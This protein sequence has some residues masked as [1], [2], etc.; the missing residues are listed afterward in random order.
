MQ[1]QQAFG[2]ERSMQQPPATRWFT[3]VVGLALLAAVIA[4]S[5]H[6]SES[7]TFARLAERARPGWILLAIGLQLGTHLAQGQVFRIVARAGGFA[8]GFATACRLGLAKLFVDQAVPSAG[9]SGTVVLA[10]GLERR[11]MRRPVVAAGVAV[12][13]ASYYAAYVACLAVALALATARG[14]LNALILVASL[15]LVVFAAA[16]S[17]VVIAMS[18]RSVY[19]L[20][21]ALLRLKVVRSVFGFIG[22]ADPAL[23]RSTRLLLSTTFYQVV[24]VLCDAASVWVLLRSLGSHGSPSG[25]FASF[26]VSSLLRTIGFTPGGLGTFEAASVV[27]LRMIGVPL[28]AALAATLLFRGLSFWLPMLPGLWFSHREVSQRSAERRDGVA[29][30][31]DASGTLAGLLSGLATSERGL[32]AVEAAQRLSLVRPTESRTKHLRARVLDFLRTA[33]SPL[34]LI[35]LAAGS[36]SAFLRDLSDALLIAAI[37]LASTIINLWQ[38]FRSERAAA[39]L[40]DRI[41][42]TAT[43][44]RDGAWSEVPR[45]DIVTGDIIRLSAGDLVPADARLIEASDLHVHQAALNGESLPAE[46]VPVRG[47]LSTKGADSPALV[48]LGTSIVSGTAIAVVYA[49]GRDTAF[50]DIVERLAARP[51]ETEFERG[52]R[53]FGLLILQTVMFLV[54]FILV[55]N[56]SLGRDALESL[57]FSVALA[58]GLT[59]EFLPM[60]TSVTLTQGAVR[61]AREKVIVKH[62]AAIQNLGSI[63][64]LCS[65]KTGTLTSGTMALDASLDPAGHPHDR[66]LSL[67][68]LNSAFESGIKSPLDSAILARASSGANG[69][70]KIDE[71]PF[72]FE[73]RRLSVAV[74]CDEQ[75]LLIT[76]GAPESVLPVCVDYELAGRVHAL[77]DAARTRC[78]ETFRTLS[79]RGFRVLAVAYRR[80]PA[81]QDLGASDER[82]LTL[83]GFLTFA[84]HLLDGAG[85]T[86]AKLRDDGVA[87]KIL[88]GD[89]ELVTRYLCEQ[90]GIPAPRIVLGR[91][92][93][94]LDQLALGRLAQQTDVF[95]RVSPAQKQQIILAL[96]ASGHVVGFLGDGIN[97]A[98]SLHGADVGISAAGAVDVAREASDILLLERR[99]DVLHS[100]ILA[101]RRAFGNV[102][103]Y[104]LMGTSSNFG[105]MISMAG[106]AL[107]LPFLPMLPTQIL[108]NNLLYDVAQLTIPT[109]TVDA[110]YLAWPQR[111]DISNIRRFMLW[112]GPVSSLFDVLTF[113]AL[114]ELFHFDQ[115]AFHTGWFVES[116][117]TQVLVLFVIRT[118]GRPWK[119]APSVPLVATSLL[120]VLVGAILPYTPLAGTLGMVVLP[121]QYLLFVALIIPIY[122]TAVELLKGWLVRRVFMAQPSAA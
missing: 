80:L 40:S 17:T 122:L 9:L 43:A 37:V 45:A 93:E 103:K 119:S 115:A 71:I 55:V 2:P 51:D 3:W 61:M 14:E 10:N 60:I 13:L 12:D 112:L 35:L 67:G 84:D 104:L 102:F 117:A 118:R 69:C 24:V 110:S 116:L 29:N 68:Q 11:G 26:M 87:L 50:G 66:A 85:V 48:F 75:I 121:F 23:T 27:T 4:A 82:E 46:K 65:D 39:Q 108:L 21:R 15:V 1:T 99:L 18:G 42:P 73:R 78:A 38:T 90:V 63:D 22:G 83:A 33:A 105:N 36:V 97:D 53:K 44:R 58:V 95:A 8:L 16:I 94:Y 91:E 31:H 32:S 52:A 74:R 79:E 70:T 5:H 100:G 114:L 54:L 81:V 57:L 49:V 111:W 6:F 77:D 107:F 89:N 19:R 86:I 30:A 72:D 47:V 98:P 34:V 101:G 25:V 120:M 20:P 88:T 64:V 96:R 56:V 7:Q 59:P 113:V 106:A 76:K 109:D 62:L 92:I 41:A 28:A